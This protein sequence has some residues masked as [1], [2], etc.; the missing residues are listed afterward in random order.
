MYICDVDFYYKINIEITIV[1][2]KRSFVR[3]SE[4]GLR[5]RKSRRLSGAQALLPATMTCAGGGE[6]GAGVGEII[7]F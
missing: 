1:Y 5:G 6:A 2:D 3:N 7:L 4:E